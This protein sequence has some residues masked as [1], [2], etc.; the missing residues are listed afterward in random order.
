M[1]GDADELGKE[2][3]R[4]PYTI[5]KKTRHDYILLDN[6]NARHMYSGVE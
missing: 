2:V 1:T 5:I 4:W 3:R 6:K